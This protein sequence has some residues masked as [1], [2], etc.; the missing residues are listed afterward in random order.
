MSR[1]QRVAR[2]VIESYC[3]GVHYHAQELERE[4]MSEKIERQGEK[5]RKERKM[6]E[7]ERECV[8]VYV[9]V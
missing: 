3:N 8:C 2:K 9:Y 4:A 7:R 6:R 1:T 5:E